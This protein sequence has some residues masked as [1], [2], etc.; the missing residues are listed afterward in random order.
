MKNNNAKFAIIGL[1]VVILIIGI[2]V[3]LVTRP[4]T[5]PE[6]NSF[7]AEDIAFEESLKGIE[8]ATVTDFNEEKAL[9]IADEYI[10]ALNDEDWAT[11]EKYSKG[12]TSALRKYQLSDMVIVDNSSGNKFNYIEDKNEYVFLVEFSFRTQDEKDIESIAKGKYFIVR[13]IDNKVKV[14]PIASEI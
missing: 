6:T 11:I 1:V 12:M 5:N 13:V 7:S 10:Q 8:E 4:S 9:A 3:F 14:N 2:I